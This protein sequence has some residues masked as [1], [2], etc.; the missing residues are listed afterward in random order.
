MVSTE[1]LFTDEPRS[2]LV[3]IPVFP[4]QDDSEVW[5]LES[6]TTHR[7]F[8]PAA[9]PFLLGLACCSTKESMVE[10]LLNSGLSEGDYSNLVSGGRV[11]ELPSIILDDTFESLF[12]NISVVPLNGNANEEIDAYS[13]RYFSPADTTKSLVISRLVFEMLKVSTGD[14]SV[15]EIVQFLAGTDASLSSELSVQLLIA[16]PS[17]IEQRLVGILKV[18]Q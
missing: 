12:E 5:L 17:L 10:V 11:V 4:E 1:I 2:L 15:S 3:G 8:D 9:A 16:L 13:V 18:N 14:Q 6:T 7:S